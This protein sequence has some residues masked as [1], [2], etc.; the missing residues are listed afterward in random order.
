MIDVLVVD[1]NPIVRA[2]LQGFLSTTD[3][4]NVVAEAADGREAL[5]AARRLRPTV[6]LLDY[7]MPIADG[8]SVITDISQ[9]STVL[10]LTSD[11]DPALIASMLRGGA[12]GYLIHGEFDPGELLRAV[13][14]VAD[15]QGWLSPAAAAAATATVRDS[16]AR[17]QAQHAEAE[18]Q[19]QARARLGLTQREEM[20]LALLSEGLSNAAIARRLVITEKTVKNHLHNI[21]AKLRVS[22]RTEAIVRWMGRK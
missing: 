15:G 8:L 9:Y 12:R 13:R 18:R 21:F 5:A 22:N 17:E 1:D 6:T 4:V 7:R 11:D 14:A 2:A 20:V 10:V 16:M 19:R 3:E